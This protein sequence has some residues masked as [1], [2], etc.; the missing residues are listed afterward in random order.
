MAFPV[1]SHLPRNGIPQDISSQILS[2]VST[3]SVKQL[4]A[5]LAQSWIAELDE[6]ILHTKTK[7]HERIHADLPVFEEQ[8]ET[9]KSVQERLQTLTTN[10]DDL[11]DSVTNTETGLIPTLLHALSAHAA[12]AQQTEDAEVMHESLDH[13][14]RCRTEFEALETL[15]GEGRL[16]EAVAASA[17]FEEQLGE[18]PVPLARSEALSQLRSRFRV[19]KD[20]IEEQ[21]GDAYARSIVISSR[22]IIIRPSVQVRQSST[23]LDLPSVFSSL[24]PA[25]LSNHLGTLRRDITTHYIDYLLTQP[26]SLAHSFAKDA[27]GMPQ[28]MISI[29]P[30]P[31]NAEDRAAQL[32][33]I[34]TIF[35]FLDTHLFPAVPIAH[36]RSFK[37]S[38]CKPITKALL[39]SFLIPLLPSSLPALPAFILLVQQAV[40]IEEQFVVGML[41][42]DARDREVKAWAEGVS[43]HYERKRRAEILE[44]ARQVIAKPDVKG[45][46]SVEVDPPDQPPNG[47]AALPIPAEEFHAD[48]A[49]GLEDDA[50]EAAADAGDEDGWGFDDE[51]SE[52]PTTLDVPPESSKPPAP[53]EPE[54]QD[55]IGS[56]DASDAWG[57]EDDEP[58]NSL[59]VARAPPVP[60]S[61]PAPDTPTDSSAGDSSAWDDPWDEPHPPSAPTSPSAPPK[62]ATRL[63]KLAN[64]GKAKA[65]H[66]PQSS[67]DSALLGR[68]P[69]PTPD[70]AAQHFERP[71]KVTVPVKG[72][73]REA[74]PPPKEM[75]MVSARARDVA[76]AVEAALRE[77]SEFAA[78]SSIPTS[79]ARGTLLWQTAPSIVDLF[80]ALYPVQAQH[81]L[82]ASAE[83]AMLFANDCVYLSTRLARMSTSGTGAPVRDK[84]S[85]AAERLRV[86]GESWFEDDI[87]RQQVAVADAL[88]ATEGFVDTA[89]QERFDE[90]EAAVMKV[91]GQ[92]RTIGRQWK[93]VLSKSKH[94]D[95]VGALVDAVLVQI[96]GDILALPDITEIESHR[97]SELCRILH[98]LEGLFVDNPDQPSS[99]VAYVPS[100]LKFS[101]LSELLEASL[102]DISYLFDEGAL[103]DFEV[104]ELVTLVQALFSDT[105]QRAN[106]I[107]KL[108][109]ENPQSR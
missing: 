5:E 32:A 80:S 46:I 75:Y 83:K 29:Y 57:W 97:L 73:Q 18:A 21:L 39:Q 107:H 3:T 30:S 42:Q 55:E 7:I 65:A 1:P 86:V 96:L 82:T 54:P 43:A 2:K 93:N 33:N 59:D 88:G 94:L 104:G 10:V 49:W 68:A 48:E 100:W 76:D 20:R 102:A 87:E 38:L 31:P 98:A 69:P 11:N 63:E 89:D 71:Q 22:E 26:T 40:E 41:G 14:L 47:S 99:V 53:P 91:L 4:N 8:L 56:E 77:G 64:K 92:I 61:A 34:A 52:S 70:K 108:A 109:A 12:L 36:L 15:V 101:Y 44:S 35:D 103:V 45:R 85:E 17:A 25:S 95:A 78:A 23:I 50:D 51:S 9:A 37:Q 81:A 6:V 60:P 62:P 106:I 90:C 67:V 13:L 66:T 19:L 72:K 27:S 16:P 84:L 74:A 28:Q 24:S 58:A 79:S 105:P